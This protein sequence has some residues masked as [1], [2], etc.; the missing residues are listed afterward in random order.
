MSS[1]SDSDIT[2]I[3]VPRNAALISLLL[4]LDFVST[5]ISDMLQSGRKQTIHN[6]SENIRERNQYKGDGMMVCQG[7]EE[8]LG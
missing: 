2:V 5:M 1:C 4:S 8:S 3:G 6:K 7:K